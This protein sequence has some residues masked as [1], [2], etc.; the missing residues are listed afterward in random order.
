[1][2]S[3]PIS[4]PDLKRRMN[5][6]G[7]SAKSKDACIEKLQQL[8]REVLKQNPNDSYMR[9]H[10]RL[11]SI[12]RSVDIFFEYKDFLP[13]NPT[14]LDWGCKHGPN[15][16]LCRFMFDD[17]VTV[18][19]CDFDRGDSHKPFHDY[20]KLEFSPID[21]IFKLPYTDESFDAVIAGGVLEHVAFPTESLKEL[22]RILRPHGLLIISFLPNRLSYSEF[23]SRNLHGRGHR[24][25]YSPWMLRELLLHHG[26]EPEFIRYRQMIPAQKFSSI[27]SPLWGVNW[28]LER[29][30]PL[31]KL[32]STL[33]SV[34]I[35]R[36][37]L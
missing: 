15:S 32:S 12:R 34:A 13:E 7:G 30:W 6:A 29:T 3:E 2:Q 23:L 5:S 4:R 20:A 26:F 1:M 17:E 19:G 24:R 11:N 22:Y 28:M 37:A 31:N 25:L 10:S 14:I 18:K 21:H 33:F 36:I 35:K 9:S 16:T 8:Y 27:F